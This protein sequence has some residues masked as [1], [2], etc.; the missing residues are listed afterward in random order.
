MS[1]LRLRLRSVDILGLINVCRGSGRA[2]NAKQRRLR[3]AEAAAAAAATIPMKTVLDR[4]T[5]IAQFAV[6]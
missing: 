2:K 4:I 5:C 6:L 3:A 1:K